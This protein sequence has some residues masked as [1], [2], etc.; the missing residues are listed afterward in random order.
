MLLGRNVADC[1]KPLRK[2]GCIRATV[3]ATICLESDRFPFVF[4]VDQE[5]GLLSP[6]ISHGDVTS[7]TEARIW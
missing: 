6:D 7:P 2:G 3:D 5:S 4:V 1:T